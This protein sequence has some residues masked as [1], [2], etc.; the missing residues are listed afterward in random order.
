MSERFG[1]YI[2]QGPENLD[3]KQRMFYAARGN[4]FA[5]LCGLMQGGSQ[6]EVE[7]M[8]EVLYDYTFDLVEHFDEVTNHM[9]THFDIDGWVKFYADDEIAHLTEFRNYTDLLLYMP[10]DTDDVRQRALDYIEY[11]DVRDE[12]EDNET[13]LY[14][15]RLMSTLNELILEY[16][17]VESQTAFTEIFSSYGQPYEPLIVLTGNLQI[18]TAIDA[19][20][21]CNPDSAT[22]VQLMMIREMAESDQSNGNDQLPITIDFDDVETQQEILSALQKRAADADLDAFSRIAAEELLTLQQPTE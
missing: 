20:R 11:V 22:L 5:A 1:N 18:D 17:P 2:D 13:D 7:H 3:S 14:C 4:L 9:L 8:A 12:V 21:Q 19:L 6:T 15:D 10:T 16:A